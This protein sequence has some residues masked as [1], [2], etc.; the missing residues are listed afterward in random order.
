M[1]PPFRTNLI[2]GLRYLQMS[3]LLPLYQISE[4]VPTRAIPIRFISAPYVKKPGKKAD[5]SEWEH[6]RLLSKLTPV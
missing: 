4:N 3:V 6:Y 1:G 2:W 5:E